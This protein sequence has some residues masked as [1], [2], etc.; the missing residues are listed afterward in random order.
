MSLVNKKAN[1]LSSASTY[2]TKQISLFLHEYGAPGLLGMSVN[3]VTWG[4]ES[5]LQY[6]VIY[7]P[8]REV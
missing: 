8:V 4:S 3:V 1:S 2:F 5:H 6:N 7:A